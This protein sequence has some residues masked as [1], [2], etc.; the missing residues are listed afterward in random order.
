MCGHR[1]SSRIA[2]TCSKLCLLSSQRQ[3]EQPYP[4]V[5]GAG[6]DVHDAGTGASSCVPDRL[7]TAGVIQLRGGEAQRL[8]AGLQGLG[9]ITRSW[10][11]G[12]DEFQGKG[13]QTHVA[14]EVQRPGL[15]TGGP[16]HHLVSDRDGAGLRH[17]DLRD[18]RDQGTPLLRA[19]P[20]LG[21][22]PA[23]ARRRDRHD[24]PGDSDAGLLSGIRWSGAPMR[25]TSR[26]RRARW[27]PCSWCFP[28]PRCLPA[29]SRA[30]RS[31][32]RRRRAA[33]P[34]P[35]AGNLFHAYV[36]R[37]TGTADQYSVVYDSGELTMPT[38][39]N[40]GGEVATFP[41]SPAV[42]VL[43]GDV[44]GFYGE[45][46]PVDTGVAVNP[47]TL[48][49]PAT[50]DPTLATNVAPAQGSTIGIGVDSGFPLYSTQDRTY[51][52]AATVTPT[53]ADPGTGA[54]A[55]ATVD[56]KT[57]GI[58]AITVTSPGAATSCPRPSRSPLRGDPHGAGQRDGSDLARRRQQ[59]RRERGRLRLHR[60]HRYSH[61]RQPDDRCDRRCERRRRQRH[62]DRRRQRLRRP[63]DRRVRDSR[64]CPAG[65][66]AT[67][68]ATMDANGVG[69]R[70][71]RGRTRAPGTRP[72]R[73]SRSGTAPSTR[74]AP[75]PA[76]A[77]ATIGIGQIDVT[78]GGAGYDSAPTVDITDSGG[79]RIRARQRHG[80]G[81]RQ[82]R[83][84]RHHRHATRAPA[85][86]RR[87][88]RSSST[89]SPASGRRPR[90]TSATTSRSRSPTR[91]PTPARTTTRS[92]S[93]S[94]A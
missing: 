44:I 25:P 76:T 86:S 75:T 58:S 4:V 27:A 89:R 13:N 32:T 18:R 3:V 71:R 19:V 61:G 39:A 80:D 73:R 81:R 37:P 7:R 79:D 16:D 68:T 8:H 91:P 59:H 47:D 31:G 24:R 22:Q 53:V 54:E 49:T 35:S 12:C 28:T 17:A 36:L 88:S 1:R 50:A 65:T 23:G 51:S 60:S 46:I 33:V 15:R 9:M 85:T 45:G 43:A 5:V 93:S 10:G 21:Q 2:V 77:A 57:G 56:P 52:F 67:G 42:A 83:R 70:G 29:R 69:H 14:G 40:A 82:G 41:V 38:P 55:T 62:A 11:R 6:D 84:H 94:T 78:S 66:Q 87:V 72:L 26:R 63:A 90:T 92:R 74:S 30:S 48:S 34:L 64:T 20:E